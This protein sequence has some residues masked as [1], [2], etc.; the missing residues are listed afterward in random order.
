MSM[1]SSTKRKLEWLLIV[2]PEV[3]PA[4]YPDYLDKKAAQ[5][6]RTE[7]RLC[8]TYRLF[9]TTILPLTDAVIYLDSDTVLMSPIELLWTK[10]YNMTSSQHAAFGREPNS[11]NLGWYQHQAN[12]PYVPP[13]GTR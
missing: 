8:S 3:R 9:L 7:Y 2:N 4:K 12:I 5:S 11:V 13:S 6:W 10:F 1:V